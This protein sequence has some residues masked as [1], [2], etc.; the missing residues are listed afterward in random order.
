MGT[1]LES[2]KKKLNLSKSFTAQNAEKRTSI[3]LLFI[4]VNMRTK[5]R[6]KVKR[7]LR[8]TRRKS[9][10]RKRRKKIK[11]ETGTRRGTDLT[12]QKMKKNTKAN[13]KIETENVKEINLKRILRKLS[14]KNQGST[15]SKRKNTVMIAIKSKR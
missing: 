1:A 3:L 7:N 11:I 4:K 2:Q 6:K 8:R 5:S 10:R 9:I 14:R 13:I 15:K 12:S